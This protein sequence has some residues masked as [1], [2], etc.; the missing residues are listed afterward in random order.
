MGL[1][2]LE[3]AE[4]SPSAMAR[5]PLSLR[6]DLELD[7]AD[8]LLAEHGGQ[9]GAVD[10]DRP[11]DGQP[12]QRRPGRMRQV[13][14]PDEVDHLGVPGVPEPGPLIQ[15]ANMRPLLGNAVD[16]GYRQL[17]ARLLTGDAPLVQ[18]S[19]TGRDQ[20]LGRLRGV[21]PVRIAAGWGLRP[22]Q[23]PADLA[24]A[25]VIRAHPVIGGVAQQ[26]RGSGDTVPLL[27]DQGH[28]LAYPRIDDELAR[29]ALQLAEHG[30][31]RHTHARHDRR[32]VRVH[33]TGQ[34]IP[35]STVEPA[36]LNRRHE[37]ASSAEQEKPRST[38]PAT[39]AVQAAL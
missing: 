1:R 31:D 33:Q 12:G 28:P 25:A 20:P 21:R 18:L 17:A 36:Y 30:G 5:Q 32:G 24:D 38:G 11:P 6:K 16:A 7:V 39:S 15:G 34:L 37:Q 26:V 9:P 4:V 35:V 2:D 13:L 3:V 22:E 23:Q 8:H 19:G 27:S 29:L 10:A 14:D